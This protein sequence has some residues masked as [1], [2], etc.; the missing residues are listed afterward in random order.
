MVQEDSVKGEKMAVV[1]YKCHVYKGDHRRH[2]P[3]FIEDGG[4]WYMA[5][6]HTFVGWVAESPDYYVP[7]NTL[8]VLT[9]EDFVQRTL[10]LHA[11]SP[12]LITVP[13]N[14]STPSS[15]H[16]AVDEAEV[17]SMAEEWYDSMVT[18]NSV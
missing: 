9:K 5:S 16:V 7:W 11:V 15:S 3:G 6:N 14:E 1:E 8:K 4:Y 10:A 17:R 2:I 18:R 13:G 12:L